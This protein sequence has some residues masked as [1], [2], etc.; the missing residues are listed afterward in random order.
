MN[1]EII[2]KIAENFSHDST[3]PLLMETH[4]PRRMF[5]VW[6]L[7]ASLCC[8]FAQTNDF[9]ARVSGIT[10]GDTIKV[11]H[12]NVQIRIRLWGIDCPELH[13]SFGTRAKQF[14]SHLAFGETVTV[15]VHDRDRYGRT[16]AEI[17]LQ[18]G[19]NLNHEI[20]RAGL[21]WWYVRYARHDLELE[22][23]EAQARAAKRGLWAD[24]DPMP[25]WEFR[26][27]AGKQAAPK[28]SR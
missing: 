11:L 13:Q 20:A 27:R 24:N 26:K 1:S 10:D 14:T 6:W 15:R 18:D 25:P 3:L 4:I 7:A 16:V 8:G 21:A 19:R 28:S 12:E 23:L 2:E 5:C 9:E 22:A 17:I